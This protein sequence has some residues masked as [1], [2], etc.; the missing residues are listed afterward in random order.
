MRVLKYWKLLAVLTLGVVLYFYQLGKIPAGFYIDE[1]MPGY[2]AYSL[3]L[4]G[5]DEYAKSFPIVLRFYGA[6]NPPLFTYL[7]IPV[8]SLVGLN[9]FSTRFVSALSGFLLSLVIYLILKHSKVTKDRTTAL[10]GMVLSL[11]SPWVILHSRVGYEVSL[12]L[13]LFALGVLIF[14]RALTDNKYFIW[15][16]LFLSLSTYAAYA[17]R[18]LVPAFIVGFLI[19]FREKVLKVKNLKIL[20]KGV[21][22]AVLSQ[23]PHFLILFTPAF[24]PKSDLV[25]AAYISEQ[26]SKIYS[27]IPGYISY[28]LAF[29]RE[30]LAQYT[31][32]FSPRSLF[33]LPDPDLQR[34]APELSVFY[35]WMIVP[36]FFGIYLL[37]KKRSNDFFKLVL[38]L[39]LISPI[40]AALTRDPF[41]THRAF[42]LVLPLILLISLGVD[43]IIRRFPRKLWVPVFSLTV[44]ISLLLLWRSYFV[45]LPNERAKYWGYGLE[46]L[47]EIVQANPEKIFVIDQG[48]IKPVFPQMAFFLKYPPEKYQTETERGVK[49]NYYT[50]PDFIPEYTFANI[51]AR[52]IYWGEDIYVKQI[53]VGDELAISDQQA[54]EHVLSKIF[55]I[56][57]PVDE[58]LFAGY[59]TNPSKK[60]ELDPENVNC[61][62]I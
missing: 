59:E 12:G 21:L 44:M 31:T 16:F 53:L 50:N 46:Q 56:R 38:M 37:W 36:Y 18:Y 39:L 15:G 57:S 42:P 61:K 17:E 8:I 25:N 28:L 19:V 51:E 24:F 43:D 34:S 2:N 58:V 22:L 14:W 13:L 4:T 60:C 49:D 11:I 1:A 7:T 32:Y 54:K 35:F 48:R 47:S 40:P 41:S 10:L 27:L 5:K 45:L 52:D 6:Y 55:E 20:A 23:I 29:S 26:S 33:F 3:L 9:V 30:L 62:D